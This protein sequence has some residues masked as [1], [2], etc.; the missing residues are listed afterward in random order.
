MKKIGKL[1]LVAM[2]VATL[3]GCGNQKDDKITMSGST[4]MEKLMTAMNEAYLEE[5][6]TTVT[7]EYTGS[8]EGIK[9]IQDGKVTI[10]NSSRALK[11]EEKSSGIVENIVAID[12][13]AVVLD[14]SN[15]VTNLTKDDL[16]RIYKGEITNW[17]ELGGNDQNIVVIGRE[18]GSG[19]RSAF[20][21][22]VNVKDQCQYAQEI[23]NTGGVMAKVAS[24][25]GAIGY[26]SLDVVDDTVTAATIEGVEATVDN[27]KSGKYLLQRPFVCATKGE[28]STQSKSVQDYF[29]FIESDAGQQIIEKVGL[30]TVD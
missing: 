20:E 21:E 17:K 7:C 22:I 4:S 28:I 2:M 25:P 9:A 14:K 3:T 29:K 11:D 12:G 15:T 19:T 10:G 16:A 18:A 5:T 13:I 1:L 24:I 26:V 8:G 30:I 27:I 23:D 6:G